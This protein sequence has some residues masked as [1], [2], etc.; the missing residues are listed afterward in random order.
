MMLKFS[1]FDLLCLQETIA[2]QKPCDS[3]KTM[4]MRANGTGNPAIAHAFILV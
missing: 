1:V 4:L 2:P 3:A